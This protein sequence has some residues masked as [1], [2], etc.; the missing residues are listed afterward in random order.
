MK[1][2]I[3]ALAALA[4]VAAVANASLVLTQD[5]NALGTATATGL[6]ST[7]NATTTIPAISGAGQTWSGLKSG[8]TS[9]A[10][11]NLNVDNGAGNSGAL[12]NY[13]ITGDADRALGSLASGTNIPRFGVAIINSTTESLT[14]FTATF[15]AEEWRRAIPATS[16]GTATQNILAF[17]YGTTALGVSLTDYLTN[18]NMVANTS[19]N[20]VG[21]TPLA[22]GAGTQVVYT[23]LGT[24]SVTVT[25]LSVAP[26]EYFFLR[27]SDA[28]ENGNDAGLAIDN[29]NFTAVPTPG[30]IA[31]MGLAG[32]V[33]G[34]RRR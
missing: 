4:G 27:W 13:G 1:Q 25:G 21:T 6:F 5:F 8:G 26:G 29:F 28:N 10:A 2:M 32:V 15:S 14:E 19:G 9:G 18:A 24:V 16:T 17:A 34:R 11:L 7:N 20:I 23:D 30:S 22:F 12:Y 33:A 31:L 3:A